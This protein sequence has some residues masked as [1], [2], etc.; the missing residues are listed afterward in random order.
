M[1]LWGRKYYW[2]DFTRHGVRYRVPLK[3]E[4]GRKIPVLP[5]H[6][7]KSRETREKAIRAEER[8]IA[9]AERGELSLRARTFA[10][11]GFTEA[12][13]RYL[14]DRRQGLKPSSQ[15]KEKQSLVKLREF[16]KTKRLSQV[17]TDDVLAYRVWREGSPGA[18]GLG[19]TR[20]TIGHAI[21]NTEV[22]CLCRILKRAKRWHLV[23]EDIKPLKE[24]KTIGRALT[25]EEKLRLLQTASQKPAWETA[26]YAAVLA[27]QTTAR[28][29]EL[30]GLRWRDVNLIERLL[31]IEESKSEAG[32]RV[33]PLTPEAFDTM[34]KLRKRAEM[35]GPVA[36]Q[37]YVFA[38]FR[39]KFHLQAQPGVRGARLLGM[40]MCDF[41]PTRSIGSW[42]T[43]W[44]TLRNAA[45]KGDKEK[46]IPEMPRLANL[47]F[48]DLRHHAITV[49]AESGASEETI[50]ALAGHVSTKMLERY[51]HI[52][53]EPKRKAVQALSDRPAEGGSPVATSQNTSQ[54]LLSGTA[55]IASCPQAIEN[56]GR[57]VGTR[58]PDLY[59]VKVAL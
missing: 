43:A 34:L 1:A 51:S 7:P 47:R 33:I 49:L 31:R 56:A 10:R 20:K 9:K 27:L 11:L 48:H 38:A 37:H 35:F 40:T 45:A 14:A 8:A 6:D 46:G 54:N 18:Q 57:P 32:E 3:D 55:L 15:A 23:A 12:S 13:E 52:R 29:C 28:T 50:K 22:G 41:D 16:F 36:P 5:D 59:R 42:R 2:G 19:R 25:H 21:I 44:R 24:P 17:T 53:L 26:Y 39:P 58:T 4:R 30:R